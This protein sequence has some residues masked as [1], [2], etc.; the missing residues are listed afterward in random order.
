MIVSMKKLLALI[1]IFPILS[2]NPTSG[3]QNSANDSGGWLFLIG[4][5]ILIFIV[6]GFA[7]LKDKFYEARRTKVE[8]DISED[9]EINEN[10]DYLDDNLSKEDA[11]V[12][13]YKKHAKKIAKELYVKEDNN[14]KSQMNVVSREPF[15]VLTIL[16]LLVGMYFQYTKYR[17]DSFSRITQCFADVIPDTEQDFCESFYEKYRDSKITLSDADTVIHDCWDE[18]LLFCKQ[19]GLGDE[20]TFGTMNYCKT[21][22]PDHWE[23]YNDNN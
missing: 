6:G 17:E 10:D 21:K 16:V 20:C 4:A 23:V 15:Y 18:R 12:D 13:T 3:W 2:A 5:W 7:N 9:E 11:F 8:H 14:P 1:L 22:H 19:E